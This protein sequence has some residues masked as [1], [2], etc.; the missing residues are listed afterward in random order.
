MIELR[1]L[2]PV[3][4]T[5]LPDE[6]AAA[7]VRQPKRLALA[8]FLCVAGRT[9]GVRR[10]V[11]LALFWPEL[12]E[13]R[14]RAALRQAL[15]FLRQ[16]FGD[17]VFETRR[18]ALAVADERVRTDVADF[19]DAIA[20]ERWADA[21]ALYRGPLLD[22]FHPAGVGAAFEDWL[23]RER[24]RLHD[25]V[26]LAV[27][28]LGRASEAGGDLRGA[29]CWARRAVEL[30]QLHEATTRR[31]MRLLAA[32]DDSAGALVAYEAL[33]RR[34][35]DEHGTAPAPATAALAE[36]CR[37]AT[38]AVT[39]DRA[40]SPVHA[41]SRTRPPT[42]AGAPVAAVAADLPPPRPADLPAPDRAAAPR[43]GRAAARRARRTGART[44]A[45]ALVLTFAGAVGWWTG[46]AGQ[47]M[48]ASGSIRVAVLPFEGHDDGGRLADG[49]ASAV[50]A[51]L[52]SVARVEVTDPEGI[53]RRLDS[54]QTAPSVGAD[55]GADYVL[56]A[57]VRSWRLA[58]GSAI[59]EVVPLIIRTGDRTVRWT[60]GPYRVTPRTRSTVHAEIAA[61][62]ATAL[63]VTLAHDERGAPTH[64]AGTDAETG[65]IH[66]L[67]LDRLREWDGDWRRPQLLDIAASLFARAAERDSTYAPAYARLAEVRLEQYTRRTPGSARDAKLLQDSRRALARVARPGRERAFGVRRATH[68]RGLSSG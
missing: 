26:R 55:V 41:A 43:A 38:S 48:A 21:A 4:A 68:S 50:G 33:A 23:A 3:E 56:R 6:A 51:R 9:G 12:D 8:A 10:E 22:G 59:A 37:V 57:N 29:A 45:A 19:D 54:W 15:H 28:E 66:R 44:A 27:D 64:P 40:S 30:D 63:D 13:P 52:V 14:A 7:V 58:D 35:R 62:V 2:G 60:G 17:D 20:T 49:L 61:D 5:G 47:A 67:G 42:S 31:L 16:Q 36:K 39:P 32:A 34:L 1:L 53:D 11:V 25:G 46:R 65:R 18:D 24:A